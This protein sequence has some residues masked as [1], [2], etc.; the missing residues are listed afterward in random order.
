MYQAKP[1][2]GTKSTSRRD[3]GEGEEGTGIRSRE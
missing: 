3:R 1:R 2:K